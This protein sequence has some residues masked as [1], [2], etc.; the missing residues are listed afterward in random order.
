MSATEDL[1]EAIHTR[2]MA[3]DDLGNAEIALEEAM[4]LENAAW[5][6]LAEERENAAQ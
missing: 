3:E 2:K 4:E 1:A 6:A 5:K